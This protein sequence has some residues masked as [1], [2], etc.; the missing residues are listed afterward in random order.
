MSSVTNLAKNLTDT[1]R[2][3]AGRVAVRVDNA[4][5]TYRALDEASARVAGLLHERGLKPGDRVGIMMPN[6]A[7]VPVV[8]Y[9]VLRA[10]GVVVPM[11]PLLKA[12]EVAYYLSDSGAGLIFAWHAFAD[13]ARAGAE[14]AEAE[15]I[16]VDGVSFPDLLASAPLDDQVADADDED[17]A[18]IL[19]TSGTTGHPKGAE[20]THGN[21]LSNT[22]VARA[23]IVR[24]GPDDVIF[25]GLPLFHVFGQTVALNVAVASGACLTLLPRFDPEHALRIIA[26]H[27]VTVFEG[28]PT[29]Y[30]ALLHQPDRA[31][32]DTS[33]LRMC[34]SGGA[35]LP[36]EVLR[37][38]EEA[39]GV[40]VLEG[41]GLSET[42]PVASF[43][44]PGRERKPGSIGTPIRDVQMRVVDGED[45]E[46]PQ[47]EVGEIVIRGPNVMKGYWNRAEAT[48]EAIRDGWFHSGDL[49]RVDED[50][51]FYIVDRKKDLIIRG[52]YNVYPREIEEVLYE[53][54][55]VAEAAVIGLPHPALGEEVGAAVALKPGAVI[56]AEELRD[57]VKTQVAAYKYP[58]HVWIV[59]ALPKG[60]TGKIQKRDIVIPA[61]LA[62]PV[63]LL[64]L[65]APPGAGK[66]TQGER[67]AAEWGVR[68]IAA[69]DLLRAEAQAGTPTGREIAAYQARGDLVPD[70]IVLDALTP[71]VVNAAAGGG[72][73]LDG[74][75]RTLPQARAAADLAARLG[76]TLDAAVYLYAPEEVLTWR[77]LDRASQGGRAD[78]VADVISH[79]LQVYAETTGLLV[80]YYT[81][82]G[83]LVA[84]DADQP[85]DS[86]TADIRAGLSGLRL[87]P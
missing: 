81:E 53:H 6:V 63:K 28:V 56:S 19:Y 54:P 36:V 43:N 4:A 46:V 12:R 44:H 47:G 42:S 52:G 59:D 21:L 84:V 50:G 32:Y 64:L 13:Q 87:T 68:H 85:P 26:G 71:A 61:D 40:P 49:A 16:V 83:I 8:Y 30:V 55:A 41:Y 37:G 70:Q 11:N 51:Y 15:S 27:K 22:D 79:R 45:H 2:T 25:G 23:D 1:T 38:F 74:F 58:R 73:I 3:Q 7:E 80:P 72:Y 60:P 86:V 31:D 33:A 39:F 69:G 57:Y 17:T 24:A 20:L 10:G 75:P 76:V 77:L 9:G 5:M 14:Q 35:A 66:G 67:L 82:R 29:M 65:L 78:D 34:I 18:V 62:V 48:T